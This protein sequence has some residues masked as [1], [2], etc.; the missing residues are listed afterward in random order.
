MSDHGL[1][2]IANR[3]ASRGSTLLRPVVRMAVQ[4]QVRPGIVDRLCQ[5][6]AAEKR[7]DLE[8]LALQGR[9]DGRGI[10]KSNAQ[11]GGQQEEIGPVGEVQ[12]ARSEDVLGAGAVVKIADGRDP[13]HATGSS[14]SGSVAG[15]TVVS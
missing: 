2:D 15:T 12:Q 14:P 4:D 7:I 10:K 9:L 1:G 3:N 8:S 13:D 6:I 11:V 5:E